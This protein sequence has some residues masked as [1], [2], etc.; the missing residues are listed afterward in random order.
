MMTLF[1][2]LAGGIAGALFGALT[3]AFAVMSSRHDCE[4]GEVE[5]NR[6]VLGR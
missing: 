3:T 4:A 5:Y 2:F 6:E 1:V